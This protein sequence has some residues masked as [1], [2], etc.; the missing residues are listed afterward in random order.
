MILAIPA[1]AQIIPPDTLW[2]QTFGGPNFDEGNCV[3]QTDDGGYI[4]TGYTTAG[5]TRDHRDA[6][7][8]KTDSSGDTIWTQSFRGEGDEEGQ[9]VTP[10]TEGGYIITG[11]TSSGISRSCQAMVIYVNA[12]EDSLWNNV[13]GGDGDEGGFSIRQSDDGGFIIAGFTDSYGSGAE[14]V[15]IIRMDAMHDIMVELTPLYTPI[16]IPETG[17]SF[18]FDI[19]VR[20]NTTT[21]QTFDLWTQIHYTGEDPFVA[22][23]M[24]IPDITLPPTFAIQRTR[25]QAIPAY[26]PG[27]TY[28]YYAFAG[29]YPWIV[30][31]KDFFTFEKE[32]DDGAGGMG[33]PA[34]W[35]CSGEPFQG[36]ALPVSAVPDNFKLFS[37]Y[38]NPFNS[39]TIIS[40]ELPA[41]SLVKLTVYDIEGREVAWLVEGFMPEGIHQAT[42]N[43]SELSCGV[44]FARLTAEGLHHTR[45]MLLIK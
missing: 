18:V 5:I 20:N 11:Y 13:I 42:F 29:D 17:G 16:I 33:D 4:I 32:G 39:S 3:Q 37:A 10:T 9:S 30:E 23:V 40:F 1:F 12:E 22:P 45:K 36:E 19:E 27:G 21:V 15:Y 38:P 7:L 8:I 43:G 28:I 2:T 25:D 14:D 26:A 35:V 6:Y 34:D 31:D 24:T 41:A 44:Y